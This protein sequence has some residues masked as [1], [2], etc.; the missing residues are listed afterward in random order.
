MLPSSSSST[1]RRFIESTEGDASV[2]MRF[3]D[4]TMEEDGGQTK[5]DS[6]WPDMPGQTDHAF[7]EEPPWKKIKL[8]LERPYKDENG[9][10][11]PALL[12]IT[13]EGEHIY[14]PYVS[15]TRFSMLHVTHHAP[16]RRVPRRL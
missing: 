10:P 8:S 13:P 16:G 12:D 11:I 15:E 3:D 5:T 14:E 7:M 6:L 2:E 9:Q 1:F 4:L